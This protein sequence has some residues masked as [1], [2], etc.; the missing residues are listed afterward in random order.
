MKSTFRPTTI[1]DQS[2][3]RRLLQRAF[4]ATD[5]APFLVPKTMAWKYWDHRDDWE[6]PRSFVLERDGVV[7]AHA[8]ILPLAFDGGEVRGVQMIDWASSKD[9]PGAWPYCKNSL[10][11][12]I[13]SIQSADRI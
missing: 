10:G 13:S 2:E 3:V 5:D 9:S 6:S 12:S 1:E 7:V 8:G 11:C 4:G